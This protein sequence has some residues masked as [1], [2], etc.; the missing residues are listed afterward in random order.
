MR[1]WFNSQN[2]TAQIVV[3]IVAFIILF[4]LFRFAKS[5]VYS[6]SSHAENSGETAA[7]TSQGMIPSFTQSQYNQFANDL[8]AAMRG[9][10]TNEPAIYNVF[11]QMN[12]DLDIVKLNTAFGIRKNFWGVGS[13]LQNWLRKDL[14]NKEM[15]KL[16]NI[17][18][19]KGI[20]K[21]F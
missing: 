8:E 18:A 15:L 10:G 17:L 11:N 14:S 9:L 13:D 2:L 16:N 3:V 6:V 4:Y 7:L 12:N 1:K 21:Q 19:N 5:F 20:T